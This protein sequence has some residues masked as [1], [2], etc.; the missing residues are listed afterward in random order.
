MPK[1]SNL[2]HFYYD[3]PAN[4]LLASF[5]S[6]V[7]CKWTGWEDVRSSGSGFWL[8]LLP[9]LMST[10]RLSISSFFNRYSNRGAGLRTVPKIYLKRD[11]FIL[12]SSKLLEQGPK[13]A[14]NH[15]L[16]KGVVWRDTWVSV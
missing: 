2:D 11:I 3:L 10:L 9:G 8:H 13:N 15:L 12:H 14:A 1:R 7:C 16:W 4:F 6:I 5:V